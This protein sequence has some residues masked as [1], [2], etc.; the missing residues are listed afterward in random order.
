MTEIRK[1]SFKVVLTIYI[2]LVHQTFTNM[3]D[4]INASVLAPNSWNDV[5]LSVFL[6]GETATFPRFPGKKARGI[7]SGLG[8]RC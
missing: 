7:F 3:I 1:T 4:A 6:I 2:Q 5:V 8:L